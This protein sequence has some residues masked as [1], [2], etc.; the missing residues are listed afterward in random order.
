[1]DPDLEAHLSSLS[2]HDDEVIQLFRGHKDLL[3]EVDAFV[4]F[5]KSRDR[6]ERIELRHFRN[7]IQQDLKGI[8][9]V[10]WPISRM[11]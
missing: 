4:E 1:M 11:K 9:K 6:Q 2:I 5:L 3:A 10:F 8:S 7:H